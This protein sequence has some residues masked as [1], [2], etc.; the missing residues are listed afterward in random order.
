MFFVCEE[1]KAKLHAIDLH[2]AVWEKI[3]R[4]VGSWLRKSGPLDEFK[5]IAKDYAEKMPEIKH[6]IDNW[7]NDEE[8]GRQVE[9]DGRNLFWLTVHCMISYLEHAKGTFKIW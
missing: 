4:S 1:G 3:K 9:L 6:V 8:F 2:L 5:A 7:T